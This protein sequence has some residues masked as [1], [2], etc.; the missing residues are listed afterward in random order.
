MG[1]LILALLLA[2]DRGTPGPP[3]PPP[4]PPD[5]DAAA[6]ASL[7]DELGQRA[8]LVHHLHLPSAQAAEAV[9]I[10]LSTRDLRVAAT[11]D[12]PTEEAIVEA[13]E[14]V[15]VTADHVR[16]RRFELEAIAGAWGGT[17]EGWEVETVR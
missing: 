4:P 8:L 14:E 6:L 15:V 12:E 5:P 13:I 10:H 17:Y 3:P 11:Q 2:C 9:A 1:P 16:A 7:G